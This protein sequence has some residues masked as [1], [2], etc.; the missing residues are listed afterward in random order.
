MPGF[1]LVEKMQ[2]ELSSGQLCDSLS[3]IFDTS[4][5]YGLWTPAVLVVGKRMWD[6]ET[7]VL[8]QPRSLLYERDCPC[9]HVPIDINRKQAQSIAGTRRVKSTVALV[10]FDSSQRYA[11]LLSKETAHVF[12]QPL[13]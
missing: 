4:S 5:S 10:H 11:H 1:L 7:E 13:M 8:K 3:L 12:T 2:L 6:H 9:P